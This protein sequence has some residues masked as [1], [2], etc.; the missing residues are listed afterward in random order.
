MATITCHHLR[1][2]NPPGD[3]GGSSDTSVTAHRPSRISSGG[4][5]SPV[6][7]PAWRHHAKFSQAKLSHCSVITELH[8]SSP[9][10]QFDGLYIKHIGTL[11]NPEVPLRR[12]G[13]L[14]QALDKREVR[15]LPEEGCT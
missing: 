11:Q 8:R 9:F 15:V 14:H 2:A 7:G 1:A 13:C 4:S 10:L 3:A 6:L 5:P 12:D